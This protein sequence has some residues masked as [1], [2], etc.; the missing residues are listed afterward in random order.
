MSA[1]D[2]CLTPLGCVSQETY[3]MSK[4]TFHVSKETYSASAVVPARIR[5]RM[6]DPLSLSLY[7]YVYY[8]GRGETLTEHRDHPLRLL[9]SFTTMLTTEDEA[10][11]EHREQT[12]STPLPQLPCGQ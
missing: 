9:Y 8:R 7:C 11:A 5:M 2:S 4:E 6:R 12:P 1:L 3:S 10:L